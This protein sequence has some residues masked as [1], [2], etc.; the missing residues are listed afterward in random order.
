MASVPS[1]KS[2]SNTHFNPLFNWSQTQ[3]EQASQILPNPT[4]KLVKIYC[5]WRVFWWFL[6]VFFTSILCL[7]LLSVSLLLFV[8]S[9]VK[10][11]PPDRAVPDPSA[12]WGSPCVFSVYFRLNCCTKYFA[13][14]TRQQQEEEPEPVRVPTQNGTYVNAGIRPES[15]AWLDLFY[16]ICGV[17]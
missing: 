6:F 4:G 9:S 11:M 5:N 13:Q 1:P 10:L 15:F 3:V 8:R 16:G 12:A 2:K 14:T 17:L 7:S